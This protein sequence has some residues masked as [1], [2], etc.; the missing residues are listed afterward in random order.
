VRG[1][2][3]LREEILLNK[4]DYVKGEIDRIT[5]KE[6]QY[7]SSIIFEIEK[8]VKE[9]PRLKKL[10]LRTG[11]KEF[12][13]SYLAK[14]DGIESFIEQYLEM[15]WYMYE[16]YKYQHEDQNLQNDLD[17]IGS[18]VDKIL[19]STG[20][21]ND[22]LVIIGSVLSV[23]S[24]IGMEEHEL[25]RFFFIPFF[26]RENYLMWPLFAHE[27]G[28]AFYDQK[29][30]VFEH[31]HEEINRVVNR[32]FRK[33]AGEESEKKREEKL[34]KFKITW[35]DWMSEIFADIYGVSTLGPAFLFSYLHQN[36]CDNPYRLLENEMG[37]YEH[38]PHV[39]RTKIHFGVLKEIIQDEIVMELVEDVEKKYLRYEKDIETEDNTT[40]Q[41]LV[42]D[43]LIT[44]S[45]EECKIIP[46]IYVEKEKKIVSEL[47]FNNPESILYEDP[48][49]ALNVLW[50]KKLTEA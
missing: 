42:C 22:L 48:I 35:H 32:D 50:L 26:E 4:F 33:T 30:P 5:L 24:S 45:I 6:R 39:I 17:L 34:E 10:F 28:H 23:T 40:Y 43:D 21:T 8:R 13:K 37:R 25:G 19:T 1:L 44:A 9:L 15:D 12:Y 18:F 11:N 3:E 2:H 46:R 49:T 20:A 16:T 38:P 29:R 36:L 47:Q 27:F 31:F 14:L 41:M 7:F